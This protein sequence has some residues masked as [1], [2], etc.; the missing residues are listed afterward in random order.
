MH[1]KRYLF[2]IAHSAVA[3]YILRG[4]VW[5]WGSL[6][7]ED[8][9]CG[10]TWPKKHYLNAFLMCTIKTCLLFIITSPLFRNQEPQI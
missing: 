2:Y 9:F 4:T 3:Q 6:L 8:H 10:C 7:P 5:S 1:F